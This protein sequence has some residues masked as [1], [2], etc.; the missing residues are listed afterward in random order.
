MQD[1]EI[2]SK[3]LGDLGTQMDDR[4]ASRSFNAKPLLTISIDSAD[5]VEEKPEEDPEFGMGASDGVDP[6]LDE[7]IK[8]KQGV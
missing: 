5:G 7:I 6:R 3:V 8:K 2:R 1:Q 4:V